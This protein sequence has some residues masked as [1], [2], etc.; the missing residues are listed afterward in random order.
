MV[1]ALQG[2]GYRTSEVTHHGRGPEEGT[3]APVVQAVLPGL[4]L[5]CDQ[6]GRVAAAVWYDAD[7]RQAVISGHRVSDRDLRYLTQEHESERATERYLAAKRY[8]PV[9]SM[10]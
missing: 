7:H 6:S 4:W 1:D 10:V 5:R 9:R 3:R 2:E 8:G